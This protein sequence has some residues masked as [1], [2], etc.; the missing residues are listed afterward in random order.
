[1]FPHYNL[2][3]LLTYLV[4]HNKKFLKQWYFDEFHNYIL[5]REPRVK[6]DKVILWQ[7]STNHM[8]VFEYFFI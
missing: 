5:T 3:Y 7:W 1:M 4:N 2:Q 8:L 6:N